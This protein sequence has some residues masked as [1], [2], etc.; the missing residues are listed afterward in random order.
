MAARQFLDNLENHLF[1]RNVAVFT[2]W[3][4]FLAPIPTWP[5]TSITV[6]K[7]EPQGVLGL[8][9]AAIMYGGY[10]ILQNLHTHKE[11]KDGGS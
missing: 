9:W 6:F 3:T 1:S 11:I 5:I 10:Q 2:G 4:A 8:S 7:D